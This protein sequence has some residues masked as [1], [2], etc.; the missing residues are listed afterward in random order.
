MPSEATDASAQPSMTSKTA[1][2]K[3]KDM[4]QTKAQ[5]T[6]KEKVKEQAAIA[7][8]PDLIFSPNRNS[9]YYESILH[10]EMMLKLGT[11]KLS[12]VPRLKSITLTIKAD[13][14]TKMGKEQVPK[15]DLL[16]HLLALEIISGSPASFL[17]AQSGQAQSG[18]AEGVFVTLNDDAMMTFLDKLVHLILPNMIG[19]EGMAPSSF[20]E[21]PPK[22]PPRP[23]AKPERV[24][25]DATKSYYSDLRISSLLLFPDFEKNFDLFEP[26]G[27]CQVR[28]EVEQSPSPASAALLLSG[29]SI[30]MLQ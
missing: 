27:S 24:K 19:F 13:A 18:R 4:P 9:L 12:S 22:R 23:G 3:K 5:A 2:K 25:P 11:R 28:F 17:A 10:R 6:A 15:T 26:L 21:V 16:L 30:P 1:S 29:F 20:H 8:S 7:I 14:D